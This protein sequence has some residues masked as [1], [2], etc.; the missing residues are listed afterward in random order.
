METLHWRVLYIVPIL[1]VQYGIA[2]IKAT[3][4]FKLFESK[5]TF[6]FAY[7]HAVI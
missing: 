6:Q 1:S 5:E 7:L 2:Y 4:I 3:K